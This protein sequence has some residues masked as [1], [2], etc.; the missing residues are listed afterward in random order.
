MHFIPGNCD[1][2]TNGITVC[3][4]SDD[5]NLPTLTEFHN[6]HKVVFVDTSGYHNLCFAMSVI[7]FKQV[8]Y[9]A[10]LALKC[11]NNTN[12]NSFP[13]LFITK[14]PFYQHFDHLV[15]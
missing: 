2:T 15:V 14:V 5:A 1:W 4:T 7:T 3:N 8:Q 11:L 13:G 9:E 6:H 10:Q 12:I